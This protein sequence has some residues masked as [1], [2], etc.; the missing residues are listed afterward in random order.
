MAKV[1][2]KVKLFVWLVVQRIIPTKAR[3]HQK[4]IPSDNT[5]AV[6]GIQAETLKHI[7]FDCLVSRSIWDD[8]CPEVLS[9]ADMTME[10]ETNWE[11]LLNLLQD[12]NLLEQGMYIL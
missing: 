3:L 9:P 12:T 4:G 5:C 1:A 8:V 10:D 7:F 2:S 6:C 11:E